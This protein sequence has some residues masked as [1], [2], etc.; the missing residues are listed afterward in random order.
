MCTYVTDETNAD[1]NL[2]SNWLQEHPH[3]NFQIGMGSI[4]RQEKAHKAM[5]LCPKRDVSN[6]DRAPE[7]LHDGAMGCHCC[8]T[9]ESSRMVLMSC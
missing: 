6:I 1:M 7:S 4:E 3:T 8:W 5:R 2:A 9:S